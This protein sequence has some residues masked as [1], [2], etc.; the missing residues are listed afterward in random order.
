[1]LTGFVKLN[2]YMAIIDMVGNHSYLFGSSNDTD[3]IVEAFSFY[4]L[5]ALGVFCRG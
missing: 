4:V 1:M 2:V 5:S 3:K